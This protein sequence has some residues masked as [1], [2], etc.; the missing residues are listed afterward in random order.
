MD[1]VR[2]FLVLKPG[3]G[4]TKGCVIAVADKGRLI[5]TVPI[6]VEGNS[7]SFASPVSDSTGNAFVKYNPGRY[8]GVLVL[9]PTEAGFED[10]GWQVNHYAGKRAYYDAELAGPGANGQYVIRSHHNNCDPNCAQGT[11]TT[12][13]LHWDGHDYV[14]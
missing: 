7:L 13:D 10:I 8:D 3:S 5:D 11:V 2:L 12:V 14:P 9:V 6:D 1:T 4:P